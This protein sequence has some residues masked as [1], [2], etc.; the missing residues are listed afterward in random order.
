MSNIWLYESDNLNIIWEYIFVPKV[1]EETHW[2]PESHTLRV[3]ISCLVN[4]KLKTFWI[5]FPFTR[6]NFDDC[7]AVITHNWVVQKWDSY[8]VSSY[9]LFSTFLEIMQWMGYMQDADKYL[10]DEWVKTFTK[11]L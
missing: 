11:E 2:N 9:E 3:Y 7:N 1:Q 4:G 6:Y 5:D 10:I 8:S